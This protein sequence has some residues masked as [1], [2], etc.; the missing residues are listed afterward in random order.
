VGGAKNFD[1][2]VGIDCDNLS[3]KRQFVGNSG[4]V[5]YG[6]Q[7][8]FVRVIIALISLLISQICSRNLTFLI[9]RYDRTLL[10]SSTVPAIQLNSSTRLQCG[11]SHSILYPGV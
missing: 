7:W 11:Y 3:Q 5:Y 2:K 10:E 8:Y 6:T 1:R 9:I 4:R